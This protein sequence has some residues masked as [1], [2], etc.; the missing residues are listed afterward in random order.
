[1]LLLLLL[2]QEHYYR[3]QNQLVIPIYSRQYNQP[4]KRGLI[5]NLGVHLNL[6]IQGETK[7][8]RLIQNNIG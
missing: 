1:M 8:K 5:I 3:H 4:N 6:K 7:Q 2:L